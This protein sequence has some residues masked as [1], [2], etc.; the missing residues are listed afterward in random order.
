LDGL[1]RAGAFA[2]T[3]ATGLFSSGV[4]IPQEE[5][6]STPTSI[7]LAEKLFKGGRAVENH[8]AIVNGEAPDAR[9]AARALPDLLTRRSRFN[10]P[11]TAL[12]GGGNENL[13]A[14]DC[15]LAFGRLQTL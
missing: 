5:N 7:P 11:T 8:T 6:Q 1:V 3:I 12:Q 9:A 10:K 15:S 4:Q 2:P 14:V 13:Y